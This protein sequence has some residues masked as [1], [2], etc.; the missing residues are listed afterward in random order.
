MHVYFSLGWGGFFWGDAAVGPHSRQLTSH[1][2]P[3]IEQMFNLISILWGSTDLFA[4]T[5]KPKLLDSFTVYV[6]QPKENLGKDK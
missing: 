6:V 1:L 3:Q 4:L 5:G 2:A